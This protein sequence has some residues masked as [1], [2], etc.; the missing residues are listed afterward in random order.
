VLLRGC[1]ACRM[2]RAVCG[3]LQSG[4]ALSDVRERENTRW[5]ACSARTHSVCCPRAGPR[6]SLVGHTQHNVCCPRAGARGLSAR[7]VCASPTPVPGGGPRARARTDS[8][9]RTCMLQ[10]ALRP[11]SSCVEQRH[12]CA[13]RRTDARH[14]LQQ[15]RTRWQPSSLRAAHPRPR[16]R[17]RHAQRPRRMAAASPLQVVAQMPSEQILFVTEVTEVSPSRLEEA[18]VL[19]QANLGR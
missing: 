9:T 11:A 12:E 15:Q 3:G 7:R 4:A 10:A 16:R 2:R 17:R 1:D 18:C 14:P 8:G 19:T 5:A 13:G 6:G